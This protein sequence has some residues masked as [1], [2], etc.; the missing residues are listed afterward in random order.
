MTRSLLDNPKL[1]FAG[2][3][4]TDIQ[5]PGLSPSEAVPS[6]EDSR[7]CTRITRHFYFAKGLSGR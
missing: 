5:G 7:T 4:G 6:T 1:G 2:A 3:N